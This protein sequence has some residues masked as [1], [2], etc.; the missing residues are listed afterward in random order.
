MIFKFSGF[1]QF[2]MESFYQANIQ[3]DNLV[4]KAINGRAGNPDWS[5]ILNVINMIDSQPIII[6]NSISTICR[7]LSHGN[8]GRK[9]NCLILIDALFKNS[10]PASLKSYQT[11]GLM[12]ALDADPISTN[13]ELHNFLYKNMPEWVSACQSNQCLDP[14]F[15][16]WVKIYCSTHYVPNLTRHIRK[17][18]FRDLSGCVE[19]LTML[20]E[21]MVNFTNTDKKLLNEIASNAEEIARRLHELQPT[22][23]D[24]QLSAAIAATRDLC[25]SAIKQYLTIEKNGQPNCE[26]LMRKVGRAAHIVEECSKPPPKPAKQT[27][28][29]PKLQGGDSGDIS[30]A[31]FFIRLAQI[32]SNTSQQQ[33]N[34]QQNIS[35]QN[36]Q[37]Q[38]AQA[39]GGTDSLID[40]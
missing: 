39:A 20:T 5:H 4:K 13:A 25:D 27:R 30:D 16:N 24:K 21:C 23:V 33:N 22:I 9:M 15:A 10:K 36:V 38:N 7:H 17:K 31:E 37:Q 12:D 34:S 32:K 8:T 26:E 1:S 35:Q 40:F 2:H 11:Q 28:I 19:V 29:P 3:I 6:N 18:L 14:T